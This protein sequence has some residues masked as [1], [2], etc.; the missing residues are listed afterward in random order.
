[1]NKKRENNIEPKNRIASRKHKIVKYALALD[2]R[3]HK[4]QLYTYFCIF[5]FLFFLFYFK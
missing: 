2:F 3:V 1:M 5:S 4:V